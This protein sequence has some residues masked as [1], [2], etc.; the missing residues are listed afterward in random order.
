MADSQRPGYGARVLKEG[1]RHR[2]AMPVGWLGCVLLIRLVHLLL[3]GDGA[4]PFN[5]ARLIVQAKSVVFHGIG[6]AFFSVPPAPNLLLA[7]LCRFRSGLQGMR[8][9]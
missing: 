8:F 3:I 7:V 4:V 1:L 2:L 6:E 5:N 9:S